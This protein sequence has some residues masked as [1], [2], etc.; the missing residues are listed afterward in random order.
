M[1]E[2]RRSD[3]MR[4]EWDGVLEE[5]LDSRRREGKAL[6][7]RHLVGVSARIISETARRRESGSRGAE[8]SL[9]IEEWK[10]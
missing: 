1:V 3:F 9:S 8:L 4:D 6:T 10:A 7:S 2:S 5:S